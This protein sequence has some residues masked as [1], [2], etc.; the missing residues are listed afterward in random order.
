[1]TDDNIRNN[2]VN[3]EADID[4]LVEPNKK[5]EI[6]VTL[7]E[8]EAALLIEIL[9]ETIAKERRAAAYGDRFKVPSRVQSLNSVLRKISSELGGDESD[10][11]EEADEG[12]S[13]SVVDD[14]YG[15]HVW[16]DR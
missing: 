11:K 7:S 12:V 1:M 5:E 10:S 15:Y 2:I 16:N 13:S 6:T 8:K 3:C 9:P 14:F 4:H